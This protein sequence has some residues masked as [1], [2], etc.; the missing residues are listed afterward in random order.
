MMNYSIRFTDVFEKDL[1][2]KGYKLVSCEPFGKQLRSCQ[3]WINDGTIENIETGEI[4]N[5]KI[6]QSYYT[7]VS[8][9]L[10]GV[11]YH[12]GKWSVTTSKQQSWFACGYWS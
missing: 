6:L 11:C 12:C 1:E 10:D 5:I 3:A 8:Y 7:L 9:I 4:K 2:T